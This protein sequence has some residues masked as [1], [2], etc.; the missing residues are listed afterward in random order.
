VLRL[1]PDFDNLRGDPRFQQ[2]AQS[3][4]SSGTDAATSAGKDAKHD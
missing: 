4:A 1:D 2:L 3:T